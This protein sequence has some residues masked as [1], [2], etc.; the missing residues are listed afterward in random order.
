M[1]GTK[2]PAREADKDPLKVCPQCECAH[3]PAPACPE[4]S[5]EYPVQ[6]R[7]IAQVDGTLVEVRPDD[8]RLQAKREQA[9]CRTLDD[10][11]ALAAA[12]GYRAAWA[13]KVWAARSSRPRLHRGWR[14][15]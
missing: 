12:R 5:F 1:A 2:T 4:C 14:A 10:L 8:R 11:K 15:A 13:E 9:A 3:A 6:P 7:E